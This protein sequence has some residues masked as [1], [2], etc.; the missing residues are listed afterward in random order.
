MN[1][2]ERTSWL[3]PSPPLAIDGDEFPAGGPP[4]LKP[5]EPRDASPARRADLSAPEDG[6]AEL[7]G[8]RG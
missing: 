6:L 4:Q 7:A 3:A 2:E 8:R 1:S 5:A